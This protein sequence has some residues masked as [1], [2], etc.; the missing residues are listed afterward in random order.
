MAVY[1]RVKWSWRVTS[2]SLPPRK[3]ET[4]RIGFE[5]K[6]SDHDLQLHYMLPKWKN[7]IKYKNLEKFNIHGDIHVN[8]N[9][10][11]DAET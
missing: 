8:H 7:N 10:F 4:R 9:Y 1:E 3:D 5:G 11:G 2:G 6:E